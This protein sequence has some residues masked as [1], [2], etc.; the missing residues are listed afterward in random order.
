MKDQRKRDRR[1]QYAME[2]NCGFLM[3]SDFLVLQ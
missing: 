1:S 3:E 2:P